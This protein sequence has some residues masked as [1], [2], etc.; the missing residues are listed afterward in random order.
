MFLRERGQLKLQERGGI[1]ALRNQGLPIAQIAALFDCNRNTVK[2]WVSR[3]EETLDVQ[4]RLG[5]GRPKITTPEED[6][7]I[8]DAVRAKPIT[9]AAE[10]AGNRF[11][12]LKILFV[13]RFVVLHNL[14]SVTKTKSISILSNIVYSR[15][16]IK[17]KQLDYKS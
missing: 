5:S 16:R 14:N 17:R 11:K 15:S 10:I 3:Y 1:V 2:R 6:N 13:N 8:L 7:M 12:N 9:I 4:R